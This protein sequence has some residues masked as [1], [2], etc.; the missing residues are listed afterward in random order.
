MSVHTHIYTLIYQ[1]L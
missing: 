1:T